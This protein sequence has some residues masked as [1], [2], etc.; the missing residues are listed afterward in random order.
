M[1]KRIS[2]V[3]IPMKLGVEISGTD[4]EC[5]ETEILTVRKKI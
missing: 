1:P 5:R 4:F 2:A 3:P